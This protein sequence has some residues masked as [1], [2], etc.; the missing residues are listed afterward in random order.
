MLISITF[1]DGY[2]SQLKFAKLLARLGIRATFFIITHLKSFESKQLLTIN[3]ENI[4]TLVEM[5]HEVGSHTATHE[6]LIKLDRFK[7]EEELKSSKRY[8]EDIIGREV[9]G[10]AYPYGIY[11]LRV[12]REVSK[13]YYYARATD[14]LPFDDPL[15]IKVWSKY[16]IGSASVK[17]IG[18]VLLY[19][20]NPTFSSYIKP[21]VFIHDV[22]PVK[23]AMLYSLIHV[24]RKLDAKFLTMKELAEIIE[25][26][27]GECEGCS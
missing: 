15:N 18:K 23:A 14:I 9:L 5:G 4:A 20:M 10:F 19:A 26:E 21:T 6:I 16:T 17:T 11:N 1:D 8:L 22:K 2:I 24:L 27:C 25:G 7:L 13:H 3:E 12:I